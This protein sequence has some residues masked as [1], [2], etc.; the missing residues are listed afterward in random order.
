MV[1]Y[2]INHIPV[3][4]PNPQPHWVSPLTVGEGDG[5]GVVETGRGR[6]IVVV[7]VVVVV[8]IFLV[9]GHYCRLAVSR[10]SEIG[11]LRL[12]GRAAV[13]NVSISAT[14]RPVDSTRATTVY[15]SLNDIHF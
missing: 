5:L 6:V 10:T 13:K 4:N 7:V 2:Y 12:L 1:Q 15:P 11:T 3:D 8:V 14:S 9:D